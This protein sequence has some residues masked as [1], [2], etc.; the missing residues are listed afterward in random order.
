MRR[1]EDRMRVSA[2]TKTLLPATDYALGGRSEDQ[3]RP[4]RGALPIMR[5][6][7]PEKIAT[8]PRN[9]STARLGLLPIMRSGAHGSATD[10]ALKSVNVS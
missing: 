5:S 2:G 7:V 3:K 8:L 9:D 6:H 1:P 10:H 4:V